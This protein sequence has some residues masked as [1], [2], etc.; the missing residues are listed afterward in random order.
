VFSILKSGKGPVLSSSYRRVILQDTI[1]KLLEWILI[2]KILY[3][4][5]GRGLL[6]N[7]QYGFRLKQS[8]TLQLTR[9][10]ESVQELC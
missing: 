5:V 1:D 2:T 7:E 3:K 8:T 9:L 10:V 4:V 6:R